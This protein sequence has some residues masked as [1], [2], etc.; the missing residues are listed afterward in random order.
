M[1]CFARKH[2]KI[3]LPKG[4]CEVVA[5]SMATFMLFERKGG[6]GAGPAGPVGKKMAKWARFCIPN[7]QEMSG[8]SEQG[9]ELRGLCIPR[10]L[11]RWHDPD[12]LW[13]LSPAYIPE[14]LKGRRGGTRAMYR[15]LSEEGSRVIS[16]LPL[17]W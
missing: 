7:R 3:M 15:V 1:E 5:T 17:P 14:I 11:P 9:R 8:R 4:T 10:P 12:P 13:G 2:S 16:W 6:G